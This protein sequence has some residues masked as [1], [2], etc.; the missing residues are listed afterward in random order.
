MGYSL[1]ER[2]STRFFRCRVP[3]Q[4]RRSVVRRG[5]SSVGN[6][7]TRQSLDR[8]PPAC[9]SM[10]S[11]RPHPLRFF[12]QHRFAWPVTRDPVVVDAFRNDPLCF[13]ALQVASAKSFLAAS[14]RLADPD[15]LA[16]IRSDLP[17]YFFSCADDPIG[18]KIARNS[19]LMDRY[20]HAGVS[21]ISHNFYPRTSRNAQRTE[22]QRGSNESSGLALGDIG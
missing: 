2:A 20:H 9:G 18:Q 4:R 17:M 5:A 6:P 11:L 13:G 15:A 3:Q 19:H 1:P 12:A 8:A 21:D 14:V 7:A 22:P 16:E 10:L